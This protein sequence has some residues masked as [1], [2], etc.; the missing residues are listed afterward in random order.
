M[1]PDTEQ[2]PHQDLPSGGS[3]LPSKGTNSEGGSAPTDLPLHSMPT[4]R[5]RKVA[6]LPAVELIAIALGH[7]K[8]I[9]EDTS[10]NELDWPAA[11]KTQVRKS[12]LVLS[13][14]DIRRYLKQAKSARDGRKDFSVSGD[15]LED[16][17]EEWLCKGIVMRQ[18]T[19]MI[20]AAPKVGKTRL[21]LA[22]LHDFVSGRGEFAGFPLY[23]GP[24]KI[25][26]LGP[27]QSERS[28]CSY[29]KRA[30][31]IGADRKLPESIVAIASSEKGFTLDD[32][33]L[34]RI[35]SKL[36]EHGRLVVL[37]DSY[38]AAIRGEALDENKPEAVVPLQKLHNL[39]MAYDS[40]LIVIHH[41]NK[42]GGNG[43]VTTMARGS[44][45]IAAQVDNIISMKT[46]NEQEEPGVKKYELLV[47]G[48]AETEG[49]PLIGFNKHS[50]E[51]LSCGSAR[52]AREELSKD[53][54]YDSLT[55][56]QLAA[57][58]ALVVA[59]RKD[60]SLLT[61]RNVVEKAV[62]DPTKNSH[63]VMNKTLRALEKK[64]LATCSMESK[65]RAFQTGA[66]WKPTA[67]A[68]V[69]HQ[70]IDL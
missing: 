64:G 46:W 1:K 38:S 8:R 40:T 65:L 44:S 62:K 9:V 36:R 26:L 49:T 53:Q 7:A 27:D 67:W 42:G 60:G 57:L 17:E 5:S 70:E 47:T 24:E 12:D 32:E 41:A 22:L 61:V 21:M 10:I 69:K 68:M 63:V 2:S 43:E 16:R 11:L 18:A 15:E 35:E 30:G 45:A 59:H 4:T 14:S 19:N 31:F 20:F 23:P 13:D 34:T 52:E 33:W 37:L 51:W 48:R 25:L 3:A 56:A 6:P 28:W 54:G 58:D 39:V 55:V 29:L 50:G 66:T